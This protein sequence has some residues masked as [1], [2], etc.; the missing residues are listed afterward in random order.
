M[1]SLKCQAFSSH[2]QRGA[3]SVRPGRL[4]GHE[5]ET[6]IAA[7][8]RHGPSHHHPR[9]AW[10]GIGT[11]NPSVTY[12]K[13]ILL[14]ILAGG[15]KHRAKYSIYWGL[16]IFLSSSIII[17]RKTMIIVWRAVIGHFYSDE[18]AQVFWFLKVFS[19]TGTLALVCPIIVVSHWFIR[20]HSA[21]RRRLLTAWSRSRW[22]WTA[23]CREACRP[24]WPSTLW[25]TRCC[26]HHS[27]SAFH[28]HV[29]E[30]SR[31]NKVGDQ[32]QKT[33]CFTSACVYLCIYLFIW[34]V[35]TEKA[36]LT[37]CV[38][39][40]RVW[41][42][43]GKCR[44]SWNQPLIFLF[45]S[46][47]PCFQLVTQKIAWRCHTAK[48]ELSLTFDQRPSRNSAWNVTAVRLWLAEWRP[49]TFMCWLLIRRFIRFKW[50]QFLVIIYSRW[51]IR[52]TAFGSRQ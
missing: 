39:L 13:S 44:E 1:L 10:S 24:L 16:H 11:V 22:G 38:S 30:T 5:R 25:P 3:S 46:S 26:H 27:V 51:N 7:F 31:V 8:I 15:C 43:S 33:S 42:E 4:W 23:S 49:L 9:L 50:V 48:S 14:H 45:A 37:G 21:F 47:S 18:W 12:Y 17:H 20:L 35:T 29:T 32:N 40:K 41:T 34:L 52:P 2:W 6:I 28:R 36:K 19:S